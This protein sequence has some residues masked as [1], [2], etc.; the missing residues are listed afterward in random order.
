MRLIEDF[1]GFSIQT[2]IRILMIKKLPRSYFRVLRG[3]MK[4][5]YFFFTL[6]SMNEK[7]YKRPMPNNQI[8]ME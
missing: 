6:L 4:V 7:G 1:L 5:C 8:L 3:L 2:K